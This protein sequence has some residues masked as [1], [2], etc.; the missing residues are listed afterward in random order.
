MYRQ[1][2]TP[3]GW[4]NEVFTSA[5]ALLV[6]VPGDVT[7]RVDILDNRVEIMPVIDY[8]GLETAWVAARGDGRNSGAL[9][10]RQIVSA[11]RQQDPGAGHLVVYPNPSRGQFHFRVTGIASNP[12]LRL[13]IFDLRGRRVRVLDSGAESG[14]ILWD[15]NDRS[16][17]P[18]AA[19]TYLALARG[20]G[21]PLV[22]RVVLTR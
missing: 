16:G 22:T 10:L 17:R 5:G 9:P 2:L 8:K 13:E 14:M 6:P 21:L 20:A 1:P 12:D 3:G 11:V 4:A 19:G 15:G 18:L 7:L